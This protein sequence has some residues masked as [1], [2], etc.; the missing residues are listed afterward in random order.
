MGTSHVQVSIS[1][2]VIYCCVIIHPQTQWLKTMAIHMSIVF[3]HMS[4]VWTAL[5]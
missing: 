5:S 3:I 4:I 2:V 1:V